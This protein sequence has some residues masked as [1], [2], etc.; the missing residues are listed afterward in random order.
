MK[1]RLGKYVR[2]GGESR[3]PFYGQAT[4]SEVR[5]DV[6]DGGVLPLAKIEPV[7]SLDSPSLQVRATNL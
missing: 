2:G 3:T 6:A 7:G 4:S 5:H 1:I